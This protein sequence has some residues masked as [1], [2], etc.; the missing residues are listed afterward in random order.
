VVAIVK[1]AWIECYPY[2]LF[3]TIAYIKKFCCTEGKVFF[4]G[5]H[6]SF[7]FRLELVFS[8]IPD[9]DVPERGCSMGHDAKINFLRLNLKDRPWLE[10]LDCSAPCADINR[11]AIDYR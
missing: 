2:F 9:D 8:G 5:N 4:I 6:F 10:N 11:L 3:R 1:P 7:E